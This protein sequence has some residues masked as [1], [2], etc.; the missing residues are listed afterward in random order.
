MMKPKILIIDDERNIRDIFSLL[1]EDHGYE[2]ETAAT[3]GAG[4]EKPGFSGP[5]SSSST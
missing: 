1:L 4:P 2:V 3:G 5:T